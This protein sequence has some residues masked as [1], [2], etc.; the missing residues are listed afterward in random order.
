M[1]APFECAANP[2][3]AVE[4]ATVVAVNIYDRVSQSDD[5][6]LRASVLLLMAYLRAARRNAE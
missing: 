1:T 5:V 6:A 4:L 2:T 3:K